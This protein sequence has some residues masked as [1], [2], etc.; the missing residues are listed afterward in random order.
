[1]ENQKETEVGFLFYTINYV[2]LKIHQKYFSENIRLRFM[3][4]LKT[5]FLD[6]VLLENIYIVKLCV[7][8]TL[9][10]NNG[11]KINLIEKR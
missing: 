3:T 2:E 9:M 11:K 5:D 7:S 4:M 1:M 8:V 6:Y 10:C